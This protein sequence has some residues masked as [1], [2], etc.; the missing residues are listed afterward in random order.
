M[1]VSKIEDDLSVNLPITEDISFNPLIFNDIA[2]ETPLERNKTQ[3]LKII[4]LNQTWI[5]M[6]SFRTLKPKIRVAI[7]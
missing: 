7:S 3:A 5:Q 4:F 2:L 1:H 6:P